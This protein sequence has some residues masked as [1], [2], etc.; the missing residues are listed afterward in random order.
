M[1]F[2]D[3]AKV[4]ITDGFWKERQELNKNVTAYA[5]M[6][7][8]KETGRFEAFK[9]DWKE[10]EANKPHFFW[11]SDVAKWIEG[12][13]YIIAKDANYELRQEVERLIDLIEKN[14]DE[15]GYFNIYFTVVEPSQRFKGRGNH[16]LYCAGHLIEAAIA[17]YKVTGEDRF[18]RFMRK[19][20][21]YI[22]RVFVKEKSAD[23]VTPGH[24]EIE[25]ALFKLYKC[26]DEIRY[27]K[28]AEFFINNRGN[29]SIDK[30]YTAWQLGNARYD[31]T[32]L[33]VR[34]QFTAEGHSVR[35][36][37]L[38]C[39]MAD[40]ASETNDEELKTAC[41]KLFDN[42]TRK[43]MY[44]T[45]GVGSSSIGETFTVDYFLPN[46]RAYAETCAAIA[47]VMFAQRMF[48]IEHNSKYMDLVEKIIYNGMLSGVSLDGKSFF[49][50]NPLEID[51]VDRV[52][53]V[54]VSPEHREHIPINQRVEIFDCSCCPPNLV[55]TIASINDYIYSGEGDT[56]FIHQ[57]ISSELNAKSLKATM[58]TNYPSDGKVKIFAEGVK[59]IAVRI[60]SWCDEFYIDAKYDVVDGYAYIDNPNREL[61]IEFCMKVA[62]MQANLNVQ[63]CAGKVAL[64]RGPVVYCIESVDNGQLIKQIQID[65]VLNEEISFDSTLNLNVIAVDGYR[66]YDD[67]S[68]LYM[69]VSDKLKKIRIKF[70][71]Y[72]A[73]ANRGVSEMLVWCYF[74]NHTP[75]N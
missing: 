12:I 26:T 2:F 53:D 74:I 17:Y 18:L 42:I 70:I 30:E 1:E 35:A 41:K 72:Y 75:D 21:D 46:K 55:R 49:Y 57:Y 62:L 59:R 25:L 58:L 39:A 71:P 27:L 9:F 34:E 61:N 10:G 69:P 51:P 52:K 6:N 40:I 8:F 43:R 20:A 14:Q 67:C 29:N 37:Y 4:N 31:Q 15:S 22:E 65:R 36:C 7:R 63:D 24:P 44:I 73:F 56:L 45:G 66:R 48:L 33:P 54:C 28:L 16:E 5:V 64:T 3:V 47:L 11:E 60:P 32:H 23:F 19:Y 68:A 38:Y 50:E 13:S